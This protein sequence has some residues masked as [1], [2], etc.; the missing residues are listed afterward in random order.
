MIFRPIKK[1][2]D[3]TID[4]TRCETRD[5]ILRITFGKLYTSVFYLFKDI[6]KK[7]GHYNVF[8]SFEA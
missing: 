6:F 7:M 4:V 1:K 2:F 8:I 3:S 5:H